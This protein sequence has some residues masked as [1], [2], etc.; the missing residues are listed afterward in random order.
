MITNMNNERIVVTK[1][2]G[3]SM[4]N[5]ES[6]SLVRGI[7]E[8]EPARRFVVVSAPGR[9]SEYKDKITDILLQKRYREFSDRFHQI[10]RDLGWIQRDARIS[11][12]VE[13][14]NINFSLDYRVSRGEYLT[15]RMLSDLSGDEFIDAYELISISNDRKVLTDS[16]AAINQR[17]KS[18]HGRAVVPGFYGRGN[19]G[20]K[21]LPRDGSD[22]SGA[23][24]ARGAGVSTYEIFS[25]TAI[26]TADPRKDSRATL[27]RSM[28]FSELDTL[29]GSGSNVVHPE[30][31]RILKGTGININC[32]NT[33]DSRDQ[34]TW[35]TQDVA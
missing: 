9:D 22:I 5:A 32:R 4:A 26:M 10:G 1:F 3:S 31:V 15:A 6:I 14:L 7:I 27:I 34:G 21:T 11:K 8:A 17:L 13:E 19:G 35:I 25:D 2:G 12:V 30:V 24:I 23:V 33:F 16:Y 29:A 28:T 20:V 18:V